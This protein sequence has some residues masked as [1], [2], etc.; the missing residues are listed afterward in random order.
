MPADKARTGARLRAARRAARLSVDAMAEALRQAAPERE[1]RRLPKLADMRRMIRGWEAG[2]HFPSE[3]YQLLYGAALNIAPAALFG[4]EAESQPALLDLSGGVPLVSPPAP[5]DE[6]RLLQ[7]ERGPARL[8]AEV[9]E[10]LSA[11]VASQRRMEDLVGSELVVRPALGNLELILRLLRDARGPLADRLTATASEA[12][13]FAG[14]LHTAIGAHDA[15]GPLYDQALRLGMQADDDNLA[16]TALSMRGHLAWFT[17][18]LRAMADL[19]QAAAR[20]ATAPAT[21]TVAI[22][23]GGRAFALLGDRQGALRAIGRAE[24]TLTGV[25]NGE[26]P[27]SLYFYGAEFLTMQRG[28]ILA[29]LADSP[30]EHATAADVITAG[31]DAIPTAVRDAEWVAGHLVQAAAARAAA[32]DIA[33][34]VRTLRRVHAA[35][36][37]TTG[38][39]KTR[40][41]IIDTHRRIAAIRPDDP[42]VLELGELLQEP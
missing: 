40:A 41:D 10:V 11:T 28:K 21:R 3:R 25:G 12:S 31:Y 8:D 17:G 6:Q 9:I 7:V 5:E 33:E 18:D 37:A 13:Q 34:A 26:E 39:G 1:R 36:S 32:G 30:A 27:G 38:G 16:A 35:V 22:Q 15:A 4:P 19:S 29:Y 23:Q 42:D 20:L 14:W 2:E 24:E